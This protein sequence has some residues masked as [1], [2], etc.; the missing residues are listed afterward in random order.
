MLEGPEQS[1]VDPSYGILMFPAN[2]K[3]SSSSREGTGRKLA[4]IY[5]VSLCV[6]VSNTVLTVLD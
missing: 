6:L 1:S 2:I 5:S 3:D 4:F